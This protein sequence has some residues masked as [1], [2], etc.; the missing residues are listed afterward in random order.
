[1]PPDPLPHLDTFLIAAESNSFT[2]AART[3]AITQAAVSQRIQALEQALAVPLFN[4]Q[5]GRVS[6]TDAGRELY[7]FA[8]R[9]LELHQKARQKV[10]GTKL[11]LAGELTL[12]ASSIP[13]EHLLPPLLSAFRKRYPHIQVRATV[14]NSEE[15]LGRLDHGQAALGLVG[16]KVDRAHLQSRGVAGDSLALIVPAGHPWRKRRA[17]TLD[18]LGKQPLIVREA[19][20]G[21]RASLEQALGTAGKSLR[22]LQVALELG[23]NE[24][25]KRA[26]AGGLG[27]AIISLRSAKKEIQSR[28]LHALQI[29]GLTLAREIYVVWN[30]RRA[31]PIPAQLFLDILERRRQRKEVS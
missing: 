2:A 9:I 31:L 26:V 7:P 24:A 25:I 23:S 16:M 12:A 22:D 11:P 15:V 28:K 29:R 4:R 17:V 27:V 3:L 1:M 6:L 13:G 5:G 14:T 21:S 8:Q 30:E 20:S 18:D 19:G 10:T